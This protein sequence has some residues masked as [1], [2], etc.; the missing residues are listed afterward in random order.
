MTT[1]ALSMKSCG[2]MNPPRMTIRIVTA[3]WGCVK[4]MTP[5]RYALCGDMTK[6]A[7]SFNHDTAS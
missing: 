6:E 7:V 1:S 4:I 5:P 3:C 2:N